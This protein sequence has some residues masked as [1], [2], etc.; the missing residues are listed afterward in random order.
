MNNEEINKLKEDPIVQLL[1]AISGISVDE[2]L[3]KYQEETNKVNDTIEEDENV[4]YPYSVAEFK[5]VVY[6]LQDIFREANKYRQIGFNIE[7]NELWCKTM[8]FIEDLLETI[9]DE[10]YAN[11]IL[12]KT[13]D[14]TRDPDEIAYDLIDYLNNE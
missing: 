9:F 4:T 3:E 6:K 14:I 8:S 13:F 12:D 1:S 5:Q 2:I 10:K 11:V 7:Q